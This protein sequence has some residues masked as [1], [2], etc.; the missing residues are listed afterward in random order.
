MRH[1]TNAQRAK[2]QTGYA[3]RA[4]PAPDASIAPRIRALAGLDY[5]MALWLHWPAA[6]F[7]AP[8]VPSPIG[9]EGQLVPAAAFMSELTRRAR[10]KPSSRGRRAS[11]SP[12]L[13]PW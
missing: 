7:L 4:P 1:A 8:L 9:R 2:G 11:T 12:D 3:R 5:V 13:R 6:D 10:S